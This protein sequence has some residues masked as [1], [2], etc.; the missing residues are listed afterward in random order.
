MSTLSF[1][2]KRASSAPVAASCQYGALCKD[3]FDTL[4]SMGN[5]PIS[6][7]HW[8]MTGSDAHMN[9]ILSD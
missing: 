3:F 5:I 7:G 6:L 8:E 9:A 2:P 4:N 1:D